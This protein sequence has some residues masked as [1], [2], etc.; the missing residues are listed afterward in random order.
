MA[1]YG[2]TIDNKNHFNL[3]DI[4]KNSIECVFTDSIFALNF[5]ESF[6][7]GKKLILNSDR[8]SGYGTLRMYNENLL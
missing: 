2:N 8:A 5:M 1:I 4:A 7:Q 6:L 3:P